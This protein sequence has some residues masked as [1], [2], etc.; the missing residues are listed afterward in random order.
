MR[1]VLRLL[2]VGLMVLAIPLQ[3][4]AAST[5][6][7]CAPQHGHAQA[8]AGG[9]DHAT[10]THAAADAGP[11]AVHATHHPGTSGDGA[12]CSV[13]A[14]CCTGV[15]ITVSLLQPV[16]LDIASHFGLTVAEPRA[17]FLTAGPERPP[18]SDLA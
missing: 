16:V 2:L 18:R 4:L 8:A 17:G 1:S 7:F 11:A 13:C 6:L 5:M 15:A 3:G 9:H 14:A 12:D 10:H